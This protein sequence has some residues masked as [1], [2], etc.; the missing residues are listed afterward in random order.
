MSRVVVIFMQALGFADGPADTAQFNFPHGLCVDES[1]NVFICDTYVRI[2]FPV[3][4]N[5]TAAAVIF[6]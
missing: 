5:E 1:E 2:L 3:C 6:G 4:V